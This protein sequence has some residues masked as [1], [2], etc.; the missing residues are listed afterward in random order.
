V[1]VL[2]E[3]VDLTSDT[4]EGQVVVALHGWRNVSTIGRKKII[5]RE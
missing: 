3:F 1:L 5:N 4:L 2:A